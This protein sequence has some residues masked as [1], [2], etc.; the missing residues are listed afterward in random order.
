MINEFVI[1]PSKKWHNEILK[2][3]VAD[4][5][6]QNRVVELLRNKKMHITGGLYLN[7]ITVG[8]KINISATDNVGNELHKIVKI[9]RVSKG[10]ILITH[11]KCE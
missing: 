11:N 2:L 1:F 10:I 8:G 5:E 9:E 7:E 6:T 4:D 3:P